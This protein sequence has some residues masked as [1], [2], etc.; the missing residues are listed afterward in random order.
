MIL[1]DV[2][3]FCPK[4]GDALKQISENILQC[5]NCGYKLYVNPITCNG[6]IIV[7]ENGKIMLVKRKFDP[8]KGYWDLPGGFIEPHEDL[9]QSVKREIKEELGVDIDLIKI[10]GVYNDVYEFQ[11]IIWPTLGI[12]VAAKTVTGNFRSSDDINSYKFFRLQ[13]ALKQRL[14]F[15]SIKKALLDFAKSN[16]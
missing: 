2:Y 14:A 4:S 3:K 1:Q 7:N 15:H 9:E 6:V 12:V 10:I 11:D 5:N 8:K 13:E 16:K